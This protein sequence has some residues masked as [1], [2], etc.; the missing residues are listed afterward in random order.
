[1]SALNVS[2]WFLKTIQLTLSVTNILDVFKQYAL[3]IYTF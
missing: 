2:D 1:M 3:Y